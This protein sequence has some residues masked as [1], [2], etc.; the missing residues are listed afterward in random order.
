MQPQES[1]YAVQQLRKRLRTLDI[2]KA[3]SLSRQSKAGVLVPEPPR[4]LQN[5]LKAVESFLDSLRM[6]DEKMVLANF[7]IY[8]RGK[9]PEEVDAVMNPCRI[10][11][12]RLAAPPARSGSTMRMV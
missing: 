10:A 9:T 2:E 7:L 8:I 3:N 1:Q 5:A 11:W 12:R 6:R 4:D